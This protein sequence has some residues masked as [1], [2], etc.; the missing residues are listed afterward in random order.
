MT[1]DLAM[2]PEEL[3]LIIDKLGTVESSLRNQHSGA[4]AHA[5]G[6]MRNTALLLKEQLED[7]PTCLSDAL[8]RQM[9]SNL[10]NEL[11]KFYMKK[12]PG[13]GLNG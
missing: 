4:D 8:I 12:Y 2:Y 10:E 1:Y 13:R 11:V 7:D 9:V 6:N 5:V 3:S